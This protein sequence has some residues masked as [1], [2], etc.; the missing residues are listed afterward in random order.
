MLIDDYMAEYRARL[1]ADDKAA[2]RAERV[3]LWL[4]LLVGLLA[5]AGV[6]R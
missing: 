3:T 4:T 6:I 2:K 1:N 5:L